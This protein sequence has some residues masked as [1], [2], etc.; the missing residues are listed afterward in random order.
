MSKNN[1]DHGM[2]NKNLGQKALE[3]QKEKTVD[4]SVLDPKSPEY[5]D[6]WLKGLV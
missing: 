3:N 4:F 2:D 6:A 5:V 1:N